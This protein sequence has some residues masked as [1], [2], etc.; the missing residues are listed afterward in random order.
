[1]NNNKNMPKLFFKQCENMLPHYRM[2][3]MMDL[4]QRR[5]QK[6][7]HNYMHDQFHF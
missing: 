3:N 1:M 6:K 5:L 2:E 4:Q 7:N